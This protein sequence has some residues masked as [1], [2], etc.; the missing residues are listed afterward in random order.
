MQR[1]ISVKSIPDAITLCHWQLLCHRPLLS[2]LLDCL[3]RTTLPTCTFGLH[4]ILVLLRLGLGPQLLLLPRL[5]HDGD[6]PIDVGI[7]P[8]LAADAP[9]LQRAEHLTAQQPVA[10]DVVVAAALARHRGALARRPVAE[11]LRPAHR[12]VHH[13]DMGGTAVLLAVGGAAAEEFVVALVLQTRA[14]D[15]VD[16]PA[17]VRAPA[18][19]GGGGPVLVEARTAQHRSA[20]VAGAHGRGWAA[21]EGRCALAALGSRRGGSGSG[22]GIGG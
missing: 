10:P 7:V 16:H 20:F 8:P 12:A 19:F 21:G 4:R 15:D 11:G 6:G 1:I 14:A 3:L 17:A 5:A 9:L 22:I 2:F 18:V 13:P